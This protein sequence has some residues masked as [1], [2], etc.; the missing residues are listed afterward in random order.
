MQAQ[1]NLS[2]FA[3]A[4]SIKTHHSTP[5]TDSAAHPS[6]IFRASYSSKDNADEK[7]KKIDQAYSKISTE[8]ANAANDKSNK[9]TKSIE[10]IRKHDTEGVLDPNSVNYFTWETFF[11]MKNRVRMA[12]RIASLPGAFVG[13]ATGSAYFS[14]IPLGNIMIING[15]DPTIIVTL[16]VFTCGIV[17]YAF[18]RTSGSL[19]YRTFNR[20]KEADFFDHIKKNRSD[21]RLSSYRNPLPDYYGERISSVKHY[22]D[23]MKKQRKHELKG[24]S[25][26]KED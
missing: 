8:G 10:Y 25:L 9:H 11:K 5:I 7:L 22:R 14:T 1:L 17:G 6:R 2:T 26:I 12:E 3:M 19:L 18:G 13:L 16:L 21:P 23:W 20:R 24:L 15:I 4:K